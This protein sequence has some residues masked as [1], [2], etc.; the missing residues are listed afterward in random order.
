M[1]KIVS[2]RIRSLEIMRI[3]QIL[4]QN[5][6]CRPQIFEDGLKQMQTEGKTDGLK[7]VFLQVKVPQH[8]A[9]YINE[10]IELLREE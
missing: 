2:P 9:S 5:N 7:A 1:K 4:S 8:L 6:I 10:A 3:I